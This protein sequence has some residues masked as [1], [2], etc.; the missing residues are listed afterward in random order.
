[1]SK[2]TLIKFS[3]AVMT[4]AEEQKNKLL[5]KIHADNAALLE[6]KK[7][8]LKKKKELL[9]TS[10]ATK[11]ENEVKTLLSSQNVKLKYELLKKRE[12][13][14]SDMF[15]KIKNI[16]TEYTKSDAYISRLK[17]DFT[18]TLKDFSKDSI[19]VSARECDIPYLKPLT[20]EKDITFEASSTD[21]L[22]GF[23]LSSVKKR[24]FIDCTLSSKLDEERENFAQNSGF[25][26]D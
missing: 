17:E 4:E 24:L 25:V 8:E 19:I 5:N 22:G 6:S 3:N 16:L 1:M 26:L 15:D 9:V 10:E 20:E 18:E 2:D 21:I 14:I 13:L 12:Q 7:A 23:T 11:M